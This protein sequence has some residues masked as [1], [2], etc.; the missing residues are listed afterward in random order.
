[1]DLFLIGQSGAHV[2]TRRSILDEKVDRR[3]QQP[4]IGS[5]SS[6]QGHDGSHIPGRVRRNSWSRARWVRLTSHRA[7]WRVARNSTPAG[8]IEVYPRVV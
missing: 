1:M 3:L 2:L 5:C 4:R 6:D 7:F 8:E